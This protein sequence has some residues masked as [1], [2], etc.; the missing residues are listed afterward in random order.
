MSIFTIVLVLFGLSQLYWCW[1]LYSF[2]ARRIASRNVLLAVLA[3]VVVVWMAFYA[4]TFGAWSQRGTPVSLTPRDALLVAPFLWWV[5]ASVDFCWPPSSPS[6]SSSPPPSAPCW[7][8]AAVRLLLIWLRLH[9]IAPECELY[10]IASASR[11]PA[12]AKRG[13]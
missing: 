7:P 11:R 12:S 4:F 10:P 2:A 3:G 1:R 5:S 13:P 9:L 8:A 6:R